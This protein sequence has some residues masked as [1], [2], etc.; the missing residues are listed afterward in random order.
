M[1]TPNFSLAGKVAL[2]T[3]GK[4]GIGKTIA[5]A[6]AHA[7][8]DVA[9]CSRDIADGQL[10]GVADEIQKLGRSSLAI[11]AD[12]SQKSDVEKMV[13]Q[14]ISKFGAI[15]ILV[16]NAGIG[17]RGML[18]DLPEAEW[19]KLIDIDLKGCFL[20]AQAVG[21]KMIERKKGSII[22]I[23]SGM[24]SK[25]TAGRGAYCVAKAG[26]AMLTRA[27][28]QDL[29]SYSIR[30]NTIAPGLVKTEF[31]RQGWT[32]SAYLKRAESMTPLGRIGEPEDVA[33][34][35]VFLASDAAAYITGATIVVDG[36]RY[37]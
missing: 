12:V 35:A 3:G 15:D 20:C 4:R 9:I 22:N 24:A 26:V 29:G 31:S 25:A 36:G 37:A 17:N 19:D 33:G 16:N 5:L 13:G 14:V 6:F 32:D 1:V 28:A 11:Q 27:L 8:A 18:V 30:A 10:T 2:V 34:A 21:K 7:G 23:A